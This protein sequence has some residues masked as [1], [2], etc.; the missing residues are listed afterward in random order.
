MQNL[1]SN[2]MT[3]FMIALWAVAILLYS[4]HPAPA[5]AEHESEGVPMTFYMAKKF[6]RCMSKTDILRLMNDANA[7]PLLSGIASIINA[8]GKIQ[9]ADMVFFAD[10]ESGKWA[11]VEFGTGKDGCIIDMGLNLDFSPKEEHLEELMKDKINP[12]IENNKI[13]FK[14]VLT[15]DESFVI[16]KLFVDTN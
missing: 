6:I 12:K 9:L 10:S 7:V 8:Q 3:R 16:N 15:F 1:T 14:N 13:N 11:M 5:K 2:K 4:C